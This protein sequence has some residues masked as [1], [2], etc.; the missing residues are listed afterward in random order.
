MLCRDPAP[1]EIRREA[2]PLKTGCC[3]TR[4]STAP[5]SPASPPT[6]IGSL[7]RKRFERTPQENNVELGRAEA[8][9]E[10]ANLAKSDFLSSTTTSASLALLPRY[11]E[12]PSLADIMLECQAMM[13]PQGHQSSLER[14]QIQ[15]GEWNG[16][17]GLHCQHAEPLQILPHSVFETIRGHMTK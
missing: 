13:E 8:V 10:K 2:S 4:F 12:S 9:A 1:S 15:P 17:G 7:D 5:I 11:P 16:A 14:D 6:R 3:R